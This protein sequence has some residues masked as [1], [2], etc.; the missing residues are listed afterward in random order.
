MKPLS[1]ILLWF[2]CAIPARADRL[3]A[4]NGQPKCV[5]VQQAGA[6]APEWNALRKLTNQWRRGGTI[7]RA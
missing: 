5:I 2:S 4:A 6:T 7:A 1:W 3:I